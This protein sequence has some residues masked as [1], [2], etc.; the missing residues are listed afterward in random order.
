MKPIFPRTLLALALAL[1]AAAP[2]IVAIPVLA[3]A[4]QAIPNTFF[5]TNIGLDPTLTGNRPPFYN[6]TIRTLP[7]DYSGTV[8]ATFWRT[9]FA[10]CGGYTWTAD[11]AIYGQIQS[12][13]L[14][15]IAVLTNPPTCVAS[16]VTSFVM[17]AGAQQTAYNNYVAAWAAHFPTFPK[18]VELNNEFN[19]A[20]TYSGA[21]SAANMATASLAA[22]PL[23]SPAHIVL[24]PSI[25]PT[26][27]G[28]S[29]TPAS[30]WYI[31]QQYLNACA[32]AAPAKCFDYRDF[33]WYP[34]QP[35]MTNAV[36]TVRYAPELVANSLN[37]ELAVATEQGFAA[38]PV[39]GDEGYCGNPGTPDFNSNTDQW[40]GDQAKCLALLSSFTP[41]LWGINTFSY[42]TNN[43]DQTSS[44]NSQGFVNGMNATGR[45]LKTMTNALFGATWTGTP[46]NNM[47]MSRVLGSNTVRSQGDGSGVLLGRVNGSGAGCTSP[48]ASSSGGSLPTTWFASNASS[49]AGASVVVDAIDTI[50]HTVTVEI[51]GNVTTNGSGAAVITIYF[52]NPG[53]LA[54]SGDTW[55][56]GYCS[57]MTAGSMANF[58]YIAPTI[59]ETGGVSA[60]VND[61]Y[62]FPALNQKLCYQMRTLTSG[63]G[64]TRAVPQETNVIYYNGN[65]TVGTKPFDITR[66]YSTVTLDQGTVWFGN[67]SKK[68]GCNGTLA[69]SADGSSQSLATSQAFQSDIYGQTAPITGG[70]A[71][72]TGMPSFLTSCPTSGFYVAPAYGGSD[73]FV[74]TSILGPFATLSKC[75]TAMQASP[76]IKSCIARGP[77]SGT[78]FI[79][80]SGETWVPFPGDPKG[81]AIINLTAS[82]SGANAANGN[83]GSS[84]ITISGLTFNGSGNDGNGLF[85]FD[86]GT[87]INVQ[88]STF[89]LSGA[90]QALVIYNPQRSNYRGNTF[91]AP[92]N[93][94]VNMIS[95][96]SDDGIT[97]QSVTLSDSDLSGCDRFCIEWIYNAL[98]IVKDA[99]IDR[100]NITNFHGTTGFGAISFVGGTSASN[101]NVTVDSNVITNT[102]ANTELLVGVEA[103]IVN[104]TYRYNQV[105]YL[106]F[107]MSISRGTG[108]AILD[109]T[110]TMSSLFTP[111]GFG[112]LTPG[113][114][115]DGNETVVTNT[116]IGG[117]SNLVT[118]CVSGTTGFCTL[119]HGAYGATPPLST[120]SPVWTQ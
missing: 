84:N 58:D 21:I 65:G 24:A 119:G 28:A 73:T 74:G 59:N 18:Y 36:P 114:S 2:A 35:F 70:T 47:Y 11:D 44:G 13:G 115:Y 5:G 120:P 67:Y 20:S 112:A 7:A 66:T 54:S 16:P 60:F 19:A 81:S 49:G 90:Q 55:T 39:T 93:N 80:G 87:N 50:N 77:I 12:W 101:S 34:N 46:V 63:S 42:G 102:A 8:N 83:G 25:A 3:I 86:S 53:A 38:Y 109:N 37:Q 103:D 33:H 15:G 78:S 72:I 71:T 79:T 92:G 51:C 10:G 61:A 68:N 64:M 89:N 9:A 98:A 96:I 91:T 94:G 76:T 82:R 105:N 57:T 26:S 41:S 17:S 88:N 31:Y 113:G 108:V 22:Y 1:S 43:I 30:D 95:V 100:M 23:L 27:S 14:Q 69:W 45:A 85:E 52:D 48:R 97:T 106:P 107:A 62:L 104:A 56:L 4:D 99:H 75:H 29:P 32:A 40:A 111:G 110:F 116:M 118:G 117:S 6:Y